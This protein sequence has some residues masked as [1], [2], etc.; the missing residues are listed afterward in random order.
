[1]GADDVTQTLHDAL[2]RA[3]LEQA[4]ARQRP[5]LH[6]DNGPC[7]VSRSLGENLADKGM[8]TVGELVGRGLPLTVDPSE[9]HQTRHVVSSI[10]PDRCIGCGLCVTTCEPQALSLIRKAENEIYRSSMP[11]IVLEMLLLRMVY[12]KGLLPLDDALAKLNQLEKK[13]FTSL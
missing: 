6:S 12:L 7:H 5:R 13:L 3:G 4:S 8:G 1:M 9:H 10:D 2:A 11:Q